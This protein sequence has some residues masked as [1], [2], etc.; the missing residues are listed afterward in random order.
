VAGA[1][2][3]DAIRLLLVDSTGSI[4]HTH[5]WALPQTMRIID[6]SRVATTGTG[7]YISPVAGLSRVTPALGSDRSLPS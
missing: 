5:T 4:S 1:T 3:R 7:L 2:A 6:T